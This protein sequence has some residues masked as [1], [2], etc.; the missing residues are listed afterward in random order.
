M[1]KVQEV[2]EM[3]AKKEEQGEVPDTAELLEK[4][5]VEDSK[6]KARKQDDVPSPAKEDKQVAEEPAKEVAEKDE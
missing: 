4:L 6:P 5:S 2:A 1:S 3:Q